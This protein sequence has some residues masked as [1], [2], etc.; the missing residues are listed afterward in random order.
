MPQ[1]R[2]LIG[3]SGGMDSFSAVLLLKETGYTPVGITILLND[4]E[5]F[6]SRVANLAHHLHLE[7][8]FINCV[9]EFNHE[10][11]DYYVDE[12]FR[13]RTPNPCVRCN[14]N[15][16][17]PILFSKANELNC[18]F[19]ATGHYAN[20]TD[21]QGQKAISKAS[22]TDKDQSFFLWGLSSK[23]LSRILFPLSNY[24]N[25]DVA[26]I[27]MSNGFDKF[28]REKSS[29]G[30][31][32]VGRKDY[33]IFL[34]EKFIQSGLPI[35]EGKFYDLKGSWL[36][37]HQGHPYYT[38]GQRKKLDIKANSPYFVNSINPS[39]GAILLSEFKD[40]FKNYFYLS[41]YKI[42]YQDIINKKE[43]E[44]RIRYRGKSTKGIVEEEGARIKVT[45]L[46]PEWG[47]APG[48]SAAFYDNKTLVGGG[49][50]EV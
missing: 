27:A 2:V 26:D 9:Q 18:E 19:V 23:M 21:Y 45:L 38:I 14:Q 44:V 43:L 3:F 28:Y 35:N 1:K 47:I 24:S 33:R 39:T 30:A 17:W 13:G 49:F 50:I 40:L 36:G 16:K 6:R 7:H 4:N 20:I 41:N 10:V 11:V 8:Y 25:K 37:K 34:K 42:H 32:F 29:V 31:C 22:D 12:Y 46:N 5:A 15:I 48:Q